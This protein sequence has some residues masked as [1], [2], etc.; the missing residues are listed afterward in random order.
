M[1]NDN[2]QTHLILFYLFIYNKNCTKVHNEVKMQKE[3]W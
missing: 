3:K 2:K 1:G